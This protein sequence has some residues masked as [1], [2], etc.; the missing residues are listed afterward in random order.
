MK[1]YCD[2]WTLP[3]LSVEWPMDEARPI[4]SHPNYIVFFH[5]IIRIT[6]EVYHVL[7]LEWV[8]FLEIDRIVLGEFIHLILLHSLWN[9]YCN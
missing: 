2:K 3:L 6:I 8:F 1:K 5:I 9:I 4:S 7:F